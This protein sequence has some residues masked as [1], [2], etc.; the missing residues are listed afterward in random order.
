MVKFKEFIN[1]EILNK[2]FANEISTTIKYRIQY[3]EKASLVV[4]GG[5]TPLGFFKA[6]SHKQN[7]EWHK[8]MITLADERWVDVQDDSSNEKLIRKYLL[9]HSV[10]NAKFIGL[11]N[12]YKTPFNGDVYTEHMLKIIARPFDIVILGMGDDGHTASLFPR[13]NN[14]FTA[15]AMDSGRVCIGITPLNSSL[16]RITLTLPTLLNSRRIYLHIT[17][18]KKLDVYKRAMHGVDINEMPIRAILHQTQTPV[19]VY[20]TL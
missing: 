19:S 8:V 9:Q 14:L 15:L 6:L 7:I 4:S 13:A 2:F 10:L 11:K 1:Q 3:N 18:S 16:N 5:S 12:N 17:G 20:W